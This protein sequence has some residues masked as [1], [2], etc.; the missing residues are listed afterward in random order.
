VSPRY[1]PSRRGVGELERHGAVVTA[2][3]LEDLAIEDPLAAINYIAP[4]RAAE[5]AANPGAVQHQMLQPIPQ[6]HN[7]REAAATIDTLQQ[8]FGA[9]AV[10]A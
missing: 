6:E 9:E 10:T 7:Q 2:E 1:S 5:I 3:D 4:V 8:K